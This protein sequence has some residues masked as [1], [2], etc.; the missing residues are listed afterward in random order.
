MASNEE[1]EKHSNRRKRNIYAKVLK[2]EN[3]FKPKVIDSRK[4]EYKRI[5]LNLKDINIEEH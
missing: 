2:T 1:R 5:K 3:K 4:E